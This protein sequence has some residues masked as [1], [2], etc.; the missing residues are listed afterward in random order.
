MSE[1][2]YE[3]SATAKLVMGAVSLIF[4]LFIVFAGPFILQIGYETVMREVLSGGEKFGM[5][6]FGSRTELI[7]TGHDRYTPTVRVG[8]RARGAVTIM[9]RRNT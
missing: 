2:R 4:G 5:I 7:V 6:K 1:E 9:A 3:V 8:D